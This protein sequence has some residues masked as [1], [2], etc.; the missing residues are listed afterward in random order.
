MDN[1]LKL[2][3]DL[4]G[5]DALTALLIIIKIKRTLSKTTAITYPRR[6]WLVAVRKQSRNEGYGVRQNYDSER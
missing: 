6:K 4:K 3:P 1:V 5:E 2:V